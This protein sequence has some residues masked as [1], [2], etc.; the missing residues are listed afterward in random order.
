MC[1]KGGC[2]INQ[3][4][5]ECRIEEMLRVKG[6]VANIE[7]YAINDGNGIRT[8]VFLKG[9][10]LKC[11][12]CSNP[13]TQSF[14]PEMSFFSDKC[15]GCGNCVRE[16]PYNAI[17]ENLM[18][19]RSVCRECYK[20]ENAF[21]CTTKCYTSCRIITGEEMTVQD[22][23][24]RVKRDVS[25]YESS[26]GGVTLSGGEPFSQ[27]EFT[28]ALLRVLTE[29]WIDTAIETCGFGQSEDYE[30]IIPYINTVFIDIKHMN[31][32][33]HKMWTGQNN[34]AIL[35]NVKKVNALSGIYKNRLFIR[36]PVI[37]GFNEKKEEIE[38][39]AQFVARNCNNITGME[40]LP[41]HKLGR[42]KY[43]SLQRKYELEDVVPPSE[44]Y[45]Q[46]LNG[47]LA[48]YD[49]PIYKF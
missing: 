11:R 31:S 49:I 24:D 28:Y 45:M 20:K 27:P 22:V 48:H 35:E 40:L 7:R 43:Y 15:I 5:L 2:M 21:A 4:L 44:E 41:Y 16:C 33:K 18:A 8:T 9:C 34:E 10:F 39:I 25:F 23:Y 3:E 36:V 13:E 30:T 46:E 42:G 38:Q 14:F 47:I 19:D 12:W 37:P 17:D 29:K 32:E 6:T 26:G 1:L